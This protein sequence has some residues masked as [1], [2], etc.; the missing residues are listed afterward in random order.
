MMEAIGDFAKR[1]A[2]VKK[3]KFNRNIEWEKLKNEGS[4]NYWDA[5][6]STEAFKTAERVKLEIARPDARCPH[7]GSSRLRRRMIDLPVLENTISFK[8]AKVVYCPDC[9]ISQIPEESLKE[10][11][12]RLKLLGAKVVPH[13]FLAT[14]KQRMASYEKRFAEKENQRK[15]ISIYFPKK[16]GTPAK[17]QISL[18]VSD[19]LYPILRSLTSEDVRNLLGLQYYEDLEKEAMKHDRNISQYLKHEIGKRSLTNLS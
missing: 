11:E 16:E 17:P 8:K 6:D 1:T 4:P 18:L 10:L 12:G 13:I 5:H 7:C 9:K 15:V 2:N 3:L 19:K 14:V